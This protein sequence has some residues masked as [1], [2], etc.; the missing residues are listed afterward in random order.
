MA[1]GHDDHHGEAQA[2]AGKRIAEAPLFC[3]VP[4]WITAL[5]C[6]ALFIYAD[7]LYAMIAPIVK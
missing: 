6:L 7:R 1:G 3:V 4:L 2:V 5:G